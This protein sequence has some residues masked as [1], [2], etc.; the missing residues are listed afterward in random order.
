MKG[1][2]DGVDFL[3]LEVQKYYAPP[4]SWSDEKRKDT[5]MS[6]IFSGDWWGS[7]KIDGA[8]YMFIK[9]ED[10]NMFLRGRSKSVSGEYLDKFEWVPQLHTFF[11]NIPNGTC[12]LGELYLPDNEQAKSTTSIM[13]CLT[14]RAISR[15]KKN[16]YLHYYIFDLLAEAN[17]SY[18][19]MKAID[20]IF[21]LREYW[22]KHNSPYVEYA[23]YENG[24]DLWNTLQELLAE[25]CEGIVIIRNNAPYQPGKRPSKDCLKIKKELQDTI[26]CFV[27]GAIIPTKIYTGKDVENWPYWYNEQNSQKILDSDYYKENHK[28]MYELYVDGAPVVPVTKPWFNGWAGSLRLGVM[29]DGKEFE[30]GSL[31]GITDEIKENWKS[32]VGMPLEVTAMEI[33]MNQKG[34]F[35]LRH[36]KFVRFRTD[37]TKEDCQWEKIFGECL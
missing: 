17:E 13:N 16:G 19:N 33:T 25:G 10:G 5:A 18:I 6:R 27:M 30:I 34:G 36:P 23:K 35:G 29:K 11:G 15:Q 9:D 31:S 8:F 7:R 4:R 22:R 3:N 28:T 24:S 32:Y 26:D 20:R 1:Y 12:F 2:I 37:L 14:E 21:S